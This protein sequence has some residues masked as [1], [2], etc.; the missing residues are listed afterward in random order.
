MGGQ[1]KKSSQS[2][3]SKLNMEINIYFAHNINK[4]KYNKKKDGR[5][6]RKKKKKRDKRMRQERKRDQQSWV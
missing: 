3:I 4:Q 1:S 2:F 6:R 5:K